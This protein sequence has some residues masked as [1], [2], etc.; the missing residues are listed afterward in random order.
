MADPN[1]LVVADAA[2]RAV[3]FV[4]MPEAQ[5]NLAHAVVVPRQRAQVELGHHRARCRDGGRARPP[6]RRGPRA[7]AGRPLPWRREARARRGVRV[8]SRRAR[9]MGAAAVPS[10]RPRRAVLGAHRARGPTS[11]GGDRLKRER[12]S[13]R[14]RVGGGAGRAGVPRRAGRAGRDD[15]APR[16]RG[17]GPA[18]RRARLPRR[19]R[20]RARRAPRA[21]C[22]PPTSSSTASTR[23]CPGPRGSATGSTPRPTRLPDLH[24]SGGQGARRRH[25]H[26]RAVQRLKGD[27]P[28]QAPPARDGRQRPPDVQARHLARRR[29]H[30]GVGT[31]VVAARKATPAARPLQGSRP[32]S[33]ASPPRSA[34]RPPPSRTRSPPPSTT[35][36]GRQGHGRRAPRRRRPRHAPSCEASADD[37][38]RPHRRRTRHRCAKTGRNVVNRVGAR[39]HARRRVDGEGEGAGRLRPS[40][41]TRLEEPRR[42]R[43]R[44]GARSKQGRTSSAGD[45]PPERRARRREPRNGAAEGQGTICPVSPPRTA[46]E[47]RRAFLDFFAARG[48]TPVPSASL[49][50][51]DDT[52]LFTNAGMVPFK[53]YFV[54]DETPPYPRATSIQKCVRAG[55]KHNDLDDVGRT[56]RHFTFFEML[57]NFS[58]GDYFK[59]EAIPWAWE[60]VT[61][62]LGLD[63]ERL[64]V[65]VHKTDDEAEAIWRD[66]VGLPPERIQRLGDDNFWRMAD[67][68]PC[69]PSS[70]IFWD[71][72]PE[73]RPRR[74]PGRR[75]GPLRRDLEPR[76]HAVR[77]QAR[78]R[79]GAAAGAE[80]RHRRRAR[81]QPRGAAGRRR[82]SWDTDVL[83]PLIAAAEARRPASPT[84]VPGHRARRLAAHPRRARPHDDV[85]RR[86]RRRAVERGARLRAAPH[87]PAR[88]A[89]RVPARRRTSSSR[90]TLVDA[91][92][93]VM[94]AR[95]PGDREA[96]RARARRGRAAKRSG[97]ARRSRAASTCSTASLGT[98]DVTGDDAFFLHDTLGFPIDL[99][100]RDRGGARPHRRRRRLRRARWRS[101]ARARRRRTRPRAARARARR[102]S[103]TAS[104]PTSS[105][106]PSSPA[107]RSTRPI[108]AKVLA[109][110]GGRDRLA[111]A[112]HRHRGRRRARPHAVLRRVRRP[113]RRHRHDHASAG[114]RVRIDDTQYGLPGLVLHR[115]EVVEGGDRRRA[116][117]PSPAID[118]ARR[119]AH[120]PQ[121]HRDPHPALGAAR[122][123]RPAR[124]AGG[125]VRRPRPAAVRLQPPRGGDPRPARPDRGARQRR[126]HRRRAGASLRD[127][128]GARRALGAI[129]FFGDKYGDIVRVLEAGEHSIELCGGTHVHAL[130]FIG[131]IK[132]VSEGSIGANLRR[133]EA[134][135]GEGALERGSTT[136]RSQLRGLADTLGVAPAEVPE[137][138][139]R[140]LGAGEGRCKDELARRAGAPGG[141]RGGHARGGG[142]RRRGRGPRATGSRPT[143]CARSPS[144]R[145]TRVGSGVV[146]LVG[147]DADGAKAGIAVAVEQGPRRSGRV[148]GGD[149][150]RRGEGAGWRHGQARRRGAGGGPN[151]GAIDDALALL[152]TAVLAAGG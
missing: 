120:P 137:R 132:I 60:L 130:G 6:G 70:E 47:L 86:R 73:L 151:V 39:E 115:G 29:L 148:G 116:T 131:P 108:G 88:G 107:A 71:L 93:A 72:G 38:L 68:G 147:V 125:F 42:R 143:S 89:P 76:V 4:G 146:A 95:L 36:A 55:G 5:L 110:V 138:V 140:L 104:S 141:R 80:H 30:L 69:G 87:H 150:A 62:V 15:R 63:P 23:S 74:R 10:R 41:E 8:P 99:T 133:I 35:A 37:D 139:E 126:D 144:P 27:K 57:G 119:D 13:E 113:G 128:Q 40:T 66:D 81:A 97:S 85:P 1:G 49:I 109:L 136:K 101:S 134:V 82:R 17:Q 84:D 106:R 11:T 51:H 26:P 145:A 117:R 75:R 112:G 14:E 123:A 31:T 91:T 152:D 96:P 7:P 19:G 114:A 64:W 34:A 78:R 58:F 32:A 111:Q 16:P 9:R 43:R 122:G 92:V 83:R 50:P 21:S 12:T 2:A 98:G 121:P 18:P 118:G 45:S 124:E 59:T 28:R 135:T 25:R 103:S 56:N 105:A 77:R 67:T 127:H 149:R 52:L 102:S 94:G 142:G 24:E 90:P 44:A 33:S 20:A 54:G 22:A 48:H 100:A 65:T 3:E 46:D 129:A 79:A 53:P 61:E